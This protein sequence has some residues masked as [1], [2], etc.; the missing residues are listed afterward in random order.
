MRALLFLTLPTACTAMILSTPTARAHAPSSRAAV[1]M[2]IEA[3]KASLLQVIESTGQG[4][5][6][7]GMRATVL[8]EIEALEALNPTPN[9]LE[10][11]DLLTGCWRLIY[12]TSDSILG[13]TRP[14]PFK[15]RPRIL[16]SID[17]SKLAAKNEEWVL[18]G[19]LKNSV[20]AELT[21]RDDG[22]TVDVQFKKFGIGWLRIPAPASARGV[23]ETTF[24]DD[25][26]RISRG[27]KGNL[28]VLVRDGP[29]RA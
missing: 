18:R 24:L 7:P 22:R 11:P 28:F 23:L 5:C 29:S 14:R 9:P 17:A 10:A 1:A 13:V 21:P 3:G 6:G 20:R 25:S 19:L 16:Q 26:L 27:D 4:R 15:P 2:S 12:T 8:T